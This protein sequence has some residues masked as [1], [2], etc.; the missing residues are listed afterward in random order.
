MRVEPPHPRHPAAA[1]VNAIAGLRPLDE[2]E[3][4]HEHVE[5]LLTVYADMLSGR[6]SALLAELHADLGAIIDEHY[7]VR[8]AARLGCD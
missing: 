1:T 8:S 7:D 6:L 5:T 4:A 3:A 2:L